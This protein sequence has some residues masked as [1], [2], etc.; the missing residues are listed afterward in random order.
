ML[1]LCSVCIYLYS[2]I[3][4]SWCRFSPSSKKLITLADIRSITHFCSAKACVTCY[5]MLLFGST[6]INCK[7]S[8]KQQQQIEKTRFF[9]FPRIKQWIYF[10]RTANNSFF[11]L[12]GVLKLHF[13]SLLHSSA[14]YSLFTTGFVQYHNIKINLSTLV[15]TLY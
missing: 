5:G 10:K 6:R 2:G 3:L 12:L 11:I 7:K 9:F 15:K 13:M 4:S 14:N 8:M 1:N